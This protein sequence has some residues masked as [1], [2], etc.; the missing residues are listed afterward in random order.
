[1]TAALLVIACLGIWV[2]ASI[3]LAIV[4]VRRFKFFVR[5]D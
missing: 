5:K 1:M 2:I 4:V 3:P